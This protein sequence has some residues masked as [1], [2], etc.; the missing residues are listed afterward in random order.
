MHNV[1]FKCT[2]QEELGTVVKGRVRVEAD[3]LRIHEVE[4]DWMHLS[5][6]SPLSSRAHTRSKTFPI[7]MEVGYGYKA[8]G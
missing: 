6:P 5:L 2:H 3:G 8:Y 1:Q 7:K 4:H